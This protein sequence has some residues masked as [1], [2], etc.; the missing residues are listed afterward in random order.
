MYSHQYEHIPLLSQW[1]QDHM[2]EVPTFMER[3]SPIIPV[4]GPFAKRFTYNKG[5]MLRVE[6]ARR[7]K[8]GRYKQKFMTGTDET[9]RLHQYGLET[10]IS[11]E[12][13]RRPNN[14]LG[15]RIKAM[16]LIWADMSKSRG[17]GLI[18]VIKNTTWGVTSPIG[19]A[20][21]AGG[22]SSF[23]QFDSTSA[24]PKFFDVIA[25]WEREFARINGV[26]PNVH[27]YG[28]RIWDSIKVLDEVKAMVLGRGDNRTHITPA[29]L[30][31][32]IRGDNVNLGVTNQLDI[33]VPYLYYNTAAAGESP[34]MVDAFED[35]MWLGYVDRLGI[36]NPGTGGDNMTALATLS[37]TEFDDGRNMGAPL[38]EA[39]DDRTDRA[40]FFRGTAYYLHD[41]P[42][43]DYGMR[44]TSAVSA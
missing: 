28:S 25:E 26:K 40:E 24:T 15:D 44:I 13:I 1:T 37:W 5:D 12:D 20:S 9:V 21:G 27:A 23:V 29:Y 14:P 22:G 19:S 4:D 8:F 43:L 17:L 32:A 30:A 39:R 10:A 34:V 41:T 31:D 18:N 2:I 35:V 3:L 6:T 33:M 38:I 16:K 7:E 36:Q 11:Y 42:T